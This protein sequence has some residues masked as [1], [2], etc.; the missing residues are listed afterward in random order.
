MYLYSCD[1][2]SLY[3]NIKPEDAVDRIGT[4]LQ[5]EN[6]IKS[7]HLNIE[8]LK[9]ILMLSTPNWL[10]LRTDNCKFISFYN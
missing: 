6:L 8:G 5:A 10:H 9:T 1:F 3:T 7:N 2:E 4:F